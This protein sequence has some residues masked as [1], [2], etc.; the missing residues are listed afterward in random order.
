MG[1]KVTTGLAF[2][3]A[4]LADF[5][6]VA[7]LG[8]IAGCGVLFCAFS[9]FI[10]LS[11][12]KSWIAIERGGQGPRCKPRPLPARDRWRRSLCSA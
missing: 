11:R 3:A 5:M 12:G 6:A 8:W 10:F 1:R 2:F 9:C 4:M 7:E